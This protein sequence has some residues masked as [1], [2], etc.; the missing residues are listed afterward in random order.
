MVNKYAHVT[1]GADRICIE[2]ARALRSA[3]HEVAFLSTESE[4]NLVRHGR[5]IPLAVTHSS[6]QMLSPRKQIGVAACAFWN[7]AAA[8]AMN[9]LLASFRPDIVHA[10][11]LYPQLSV[12]PLVIAARR[13]LPVVQTL[14]DYELVAASSSDHLG[15]WLDRAESRL[16]YRFLNSATFPIR[17]SVHR[18]CI[19]MSVAV[20]RFI[21]RCYA[22]NGMPAVVIPNFTEQP[23][24][25]PA[26]FADRFGIAFV[27]ALFPE[28]GVLDVLRLAQAL[29]EVPITVVGEGPLSPAVEKAARDLP[30]LVAAGRKTPEEARSVVGSSRVLVMPSKWEEP[31]GLVA[32][33]AMAVGTP[34]AAYPRGGLADYVSDAGGG[35]VVA[36]SVQALVRVCVELHGESRVWE[37]LSLQGRK[38]VAERHS[39]EAHARKI[40]EV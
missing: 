2:L 18:R 30:N 8:R 10:H 1:G 22:R 9:E 32:L 40:V 20:S 13:K 26:P 34:V 24:S 11:K 36:E 28:K 17:H 6:K 27:G 7:P 5:F 31:G 38:A 25:L 33:E 3:G 14:H 37:T 15:G 23:D 12:A 21:A 35:R 29:P 19:T 39:P 16:S 4:R